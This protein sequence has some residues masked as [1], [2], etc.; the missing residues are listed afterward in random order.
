MI[1]IIIAKTIPA[2][3]AS[4]LEQVLKTTKAKTIPIAIVNIW[5]IE[6]EK[7]PIEICNQAKIPFWIFW[8][9]TTF[10]S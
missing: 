1:M 8:G 6:I 10:I 7:E 4:L 3:L 2:V 9:K 5:I